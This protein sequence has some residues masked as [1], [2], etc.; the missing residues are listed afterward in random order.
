MKGRVEKDFFCISGSCGCV[1]SSTEDVN[2]LQGNKRATFLAQKLCWMCTPTDEA[3]ENREKIKPTQPFTVWIPIRS[4]FRLV[5]KISADLNPNRLEQELFS[6]A[7]N[8]LKTTF[9][10]HCISW[11]FSYEHTSLFYYIN[12]MMVFWI[13]LM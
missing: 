7:R 1:Q 13:L 9:N 4:H 11:K 8:I 10:W 5:E 6:R 2:W 3:L 12:F